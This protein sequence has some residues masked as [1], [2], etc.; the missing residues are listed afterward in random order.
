MQG[1]CDFAQFYDALTAD[2]DYKAITKYYDGLIGKFGGKKGILLDL[3]C[4]T[5]STSVLFSKMGYDVIGV[6][7]SEEMLNIALGK[8]HEGIEYLCQD[9]CAL[10]M[11]GTVDQTVCSLDSINH[12]DGAEQ[13][14]KAFDLVSLFT[15]PGGLFLF[16]V[17]TVYKHQQILGD[18]TF[19]YDL[20]DLYCVWQ[21]QYA[22]EGKTDFFL[23]FFAGEKGVYR[24]YYD[25][26]SEQ[27]YPL[28]QMNEML[29]RAGFE[30]L[31]CYEYLTENQP[32]DIS[33]K[34]TYVVR[35]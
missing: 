24:R 6:D 14:Q 26:F 18:N 15:N 2:V 9:M 12:L 32:S 30:I 16:D 28:E 27:A 11:Y 1:Y 22:G 13:V 7:G 20:E 3:A 8:E 4:G 5:G 29:K 19:V 10:D 33:E 34:V 23:D 25:E 21:N 35:K 31:A 17:N